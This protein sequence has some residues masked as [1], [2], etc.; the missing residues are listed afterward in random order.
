MQE[1]PAGLR[2]ASMTAPS[3]LANFTRDTPGVAAAHVL[4]C[5]ERG[6]PTFAYGPPRSGKSSLCAHAAWEAMREGTQ[7]RSV[8][9]LAPTRE[10]AALLRDELSRRAMAAHG[11]G[12]E[13][14]RELPTIMTPLAYAFALVSEEAARNGRAQPSLVTGADQDALLEE[15]L[16]EIPTTWPES[17][18]QDTVAIAWCC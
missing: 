18:D 17:I 5:V 13:Q 11:R 9:L 3:K 1:K 10:R 2:L 14:R 4:E 7:A 15:L 6:I 16:A 12:A 8:V